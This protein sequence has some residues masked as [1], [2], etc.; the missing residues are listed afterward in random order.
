M[1]AIW[2]LLV[3]APFIAIPVLWWNHRRKAAERAQEADARWRQ[4]VGGAGTAAAASPAAAPAGGNAA[5]ARRL[6][7]LDPV[8]SLL[9]LLLKS[10]LADHEVMPKLALSLVLEVPADMTGGERE[11]RMRAL[12]QHTVDFV[13]CNK[14][15]QAV[16]AIDLTDTAAALPPGA[17]FKTR[18][19]AQAGIR[20]VQWPRQALPRR[21]AVREQVLGA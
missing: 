18:A 5:Y 8:E 15:M 7:T 11:Q 4:L 6:R 2:Y 9:Y 3:L 1:V 12:S 19:F 16:A 14:A 20:Y 13:I 10:R 21:D 17:A